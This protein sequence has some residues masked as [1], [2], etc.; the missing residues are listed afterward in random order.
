MEETKINILSNFVWRFLERCGAQFVGFIVG[1]VLARLLTPDDYGVVSLMWVFLT[2]F[3]VFIDGGLGN[4]LIQKKKA[5]ET[6]FSTVFYV[7]VLLCI[8]LYAV[9]FLAAPLI[10]TF[11]GL[12]EIKWMIRILG[13]TLLISGVKGIQ[14]AY[15]S[16]NMLFKKFFYSTLI[17]TIGAA[18]V[19]IAMA[20]WGF[21]AW[22]LIVQSLLNNMIDT[23]ILWITVKWRPQ[24][25]FSWSRF[26][27]LFGF[28][29]RI[30]VSS[31]IDSIY[32][33]IRSLIIGKVYSSEDLAYYNRGRSWPN[34][35]IS[36]VNTSIDSVLLPSLSK[37]QDNVETLKN[38]VRRAIILSTYI[39][40]PLLLGLAATATSIIRIV[41]TE[42]WMESIFFMRIFCII[43][44]FYSIHTS[45]LNAIKALGRTDIF[46][47]LE[48][49]KKIVGLLALVI[50]VPIS[51]KA[52]GIS[53]LVTSFV[54]QIINSWPNKKLLNYGYMEQFRDICPGVILAFIMALCIYPIQWLGLSDIVTLVSQVLAGAAIYIGGSIIFKLESFQYLWA[55]VKLKIHKA[56]E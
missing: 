34:L 28:G 26:K 17:G 43:S 51:V 53:L 30:L 54:N 12:P 40:A 16:R 25:V 24:K 36:N 19:G 8:A 7:N 23:C 55:I 41:L 4:A 18:V 45:N 14:V 44:I 35:I 48:I 15:V 3:G 42:K 27:E 56:K 1:I 52:I 29:S 13:I 2:I 5:D 38:R 50:T 6:D 39:M 37:V 9:L 11:Y 21:G 49:I 20:Y 33:N 47:K 32:D 22:A 31:V 10:A 46:L